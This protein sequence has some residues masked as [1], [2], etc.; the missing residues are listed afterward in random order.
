[1]LQ[2]NFLPENRVESKQ[3]VVP[4]TLAGSNNNHLYFITV[5]SMAVQSIA[6]NVMCNYVLANAP[7]HTTLRSRILYWGEFAIRFAVK[8]GMNGI[9]KYVYCYR[10]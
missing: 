10:G 2:I 4:S 7:T 5:Q 1:M 3:T 8:M 9:H 6:F